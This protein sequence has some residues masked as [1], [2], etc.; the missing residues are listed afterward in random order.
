MRIVIDL[1]GAQSSGSRNRGIGRYSMSLVQAIIRNR[2]SHEIVVALSGLFPDSIE[3]IR[4]DLDEFLDQENIRV[5]YSSAPVASIDNNNS[6]RRKRAELIREGFLASLRPDMVLVTSLFEGLTDNAVTS[7][8][9]LSNI[10]PTA[11][12]LYDL[13]PLI[14]RRHYLE[15]SAVEAWYENKIDHLRRA[16]LIL[17]ISESSRQEGISYIGVPRDQIINVS[18]AADSQF[19][20]K[21]IVEKKENVIRQRYALTRPFV[22]YT[23]GIDHRKNVEGLIRAYAQLPKSLRTEHQLA[24]VCSVQ[25][26]NRVALEALAK[27]Q[28]LEDDELILTGF[29]PEDDLITLYNLCKTFVFPSWHEGFGLPALEAMSCGRA[30]I[31]ANTSSLPEVIGCSD[32]MF[33]PLSDASITNKLTQ[34]LSDKAFRQ[35]LE[36]HGLEQAKRFSWDASARSTLAAMEGWHK[37]KFPMS[38]ESLPIGL[39]PKL[40]YISPLPPERSGISDY[41][42]ELLPQLARHYEIEVIS[43]QDSISDPWIKANC[44]VRSV[45]WF[46]NNSSEYERILYHFG[47][48]E[49]HQHMF[50]LL[51][52]FPGVVVLHDFFLSGIVAHMDF[53]GYQPGNWVSEL[54]K[55]HGYSSVQQRFHTQDSSEIIWRYPCNL[56]VLQNAI[57]VIT[58]SEHSRHLSWKWYGEEAK[59]STTV[60]PLL[61]EPT[62]NNDRVKAR[63]ALNLTDDTF[64]V[65]SFG[66]LSQTK[67]NHILLEAWIK[68]ALS[69]D[70]KC[71]LIFVGEINGGY[72]T[73]MLEAIEKSGLID[74]VRITG[75]TDTTSFRHYLAA[76]DLGVQLRTL[77][78]GETSAAVLD[79]MNFGLPTIVNANG[80]MADLPDSAVWKL[81][82]EFDNAQLVEALESLWR[83]EHRRKTLSLHAKETVHTHHA[84]RACSDHYARSIE[85]MYR[86]STV[87]LKNL[88]TKLASISD[89]PE[90]DSQWTLVA[91]TVA[92]STSPKFQSRQFFVDIS[93]L[94]CRDSGTGIQRMV[95][96]I[97]AELINSPPLGFRI[98]PIYA[99][100]DEGYRYARKFTLR[101]LNCPDSFLVDE[102]IEFNAGDIF[103]GLDFRPEVVLRHDIFYT[104]LRNHGVQ[105]QFIL[106]DLLTILQSHNFVPG[107]SEWIQ[108]WLEIITKF[109]GAV[110]ISK[111]VASELFDWLQVHG[112]QRARPF[113]IGYFHLGAD[114]STKKSKDFASTFKL[115]LKNIAAH[116]SFL[117]VGTIEPR[118]SHSQAVMA[119]EQLWA[120]GLNVNL[121]IVGK[122]GWMSDDTVKSI[123]SH[124]K[125]NSHL[126]WF[127][128]VSDEHLECIYSSS[129]CL[130]AASEGE[131]FGLPL[132]EA[133]RHQIPIIA[134]DI[135]VFREVAG[136]H[137]FYFT[138]ITPN[139][140]AEAI[141]DWL[142]LDK[143]GHAPKS[144]TMPWLTW[145][146]STKNLLNVILDNQCYL[147][148]VPDNV[149]RYWGSDNRLGSQTGRK[150]GRDIVCTGTAGY[151]LFGPYLKLDAGRYQLII[152]GESDVISLAGARIDIAVDKGD[153]IIGEGFLTASNQS[154]C[155]W[156]MLFNLDKKCTDLEVRIWVSENTNLSISMIE[157][158]R[159]KDE[160]ENL[161]EFASTEKK[162]LPLK[163]TDQQ[164]IFHTQPFTTTHAESMETVGVKI[165]VQNSNDSSVSIQPVLNRFSDEFN[166]IETE[167]SV[168]SLMQSVDTKESSD[169]TQMSNDLI[170]SNEIG[171]RPTLPD[172]SKISSSERNRAKA[173]RKKK[174]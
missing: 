167:Y 113:K 57:G 89:V 90:T 147:R 133:A 132:V 126:F 43:C 118:K 22:M 142:E 135:P 76:A 42:A 72:R 109:D 75:W 120:Q 40:A 85:S 79:C 63:R 86:T 56:S 104:Q 101:F 136:E 71:V 60:I 1:Q 24:I 134:R 154:G 68:S 152:R 46:K 172:R 163:Q 110:C 130:I 58:H 6:F 29:V 20:P 165:P 156:D 7:V 140:L 121:V 131:G 30:V 8:G 78:R 80:S 124:P 164:Q 36:K 19:I 31:G 161:V 66:M 61:R 162:V 160:S 70:N 84:P 35:K 38:T 92:L 4:A 112:T 2:G 96:E 82:D 65:C 28:G 26:P 158:S 53:T 55:S 16:N 94:V 11:V 15:N 33:D 108:R 5:W 107:S 103:L 150:N 153:T 116:Q 9:N 69:H 83:D 64:C 47:N 49:F 32:A 111:T 148:W 97:L 10:I 91:S 54:Y 169:C 50:G 119:F 13:I 34:V 81:P 106:Y 138:G 171:I 25:Q 93:E 18:T 146:E 41:S 74:S 99:T 14:N 100:P 122:E 23:G 52:E 128:G 62:N 174:R 102:P 12:I 166:I 3:P 87:N 114:I 151:L 137:A 145:K 17:S 141:T 67:L 139:S 37:N 127:D 159:C 21:R 149:H 105:V 73:R 44:L 45:D 117:M 77:S 48:S 173:V 39:R 168:I 51:A 123:Q 129:T 143:L 144:S 98:E 155:L 88:T 27:K 95:R 170:K 115:K 125:I 59:N 157:I